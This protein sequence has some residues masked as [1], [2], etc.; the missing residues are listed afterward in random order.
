MITKT[1]TTQTQTHKTN[2]YYCYWPNKPTKRGGGKQHTQR[3][4]EGQQDRHGHGQLRLY[5]VCALKEV[6]RRRRRRRGCKVCQERVQEEVP[7]QCIVWLWWG[8]VSE[9]EEEPWRCSRSSLRRLRNSCLRLR[10]SSN[11]KE[12]L[13]EYSLSPGIGEMSRLLGSYSVKGLRKV[14]CFTRRVFRTNDFRSEGVKGLGL[15]GLLIGVGRKEKE[16][17]RARETLLLS[18]S[19]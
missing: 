6:Q 7:Q 17:L 3:T 11:N 16:P 2:Y 10:S 13:S 8:S 19:A 4:Q 9:V 18:P 15:L 14:T 1:N 12:P 5:T